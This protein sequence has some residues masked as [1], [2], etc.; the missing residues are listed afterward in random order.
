MPLHTNS[1]QS[2]A[3]RLAVLQEYAVVDTALE[4][5][6]DLLARVAAEICGTE[7]AGINL[8]PHEHSFCEYTVAAGTTIVVADALVDERFRYSP[9]VTGGPRIRFYAGAPL[10]ARGGDVLGTLC[11]MD[12]RTRVLSARQVEL[13]EGLAKQATLVIELRRD[14]TELDLARGRLGHDEKLAHVAAWEWE[15]ATDT[16]TWTPELRSLLGVGPEVEGSYVNFLALVHEDDRDRVNGVIEA[17]LE[18]GGKFSFRT[19]IVRPDGAVRT[20]D[21]RGE[22]WL[23]AAGEPVGLWGATAD[24]TEI[25]ETEGR[26]REQADG[27]EA[28]FLTALDPIFVADSERRFIQAN[29]AAIRLL[30]YTIEQLLEM[31]VEDVVATPPEDAIA[32]WKSFLEDGHQHGEIQLRRA[33]GL[34]GRAQLGRADVALIEQI[35]DRFDQH[36]GFVRCDQRRL[37]FVGEEHRLHC[38]GGDSVYA[39]DAQD[40]EQ[41]V[42]P[43]PLRSD[44]HR[45]QRRLRRAP[46]HRR[47]RVVRA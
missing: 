3:D 27:L 33:D 7:M 37:A 18:S 28:A 17:A 8:V 30:G 35:L 20:F 29:P 47:E 4:P 39:A 31:R 13:L 32:I 23:G 25:V 22:A 36:G 40:L 46:A 19:R 41:S 9:L 10:K 24:V 2:E 5:E 26:S 1:D 38:A 34:H 21:T 43:T 16:A 44:V 15:V 14:L 45:S 11:V 6:F 42:L 12:G